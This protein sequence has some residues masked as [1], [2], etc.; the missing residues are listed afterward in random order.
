MPRYPVALWG[1]ARGWTAALL[2]DLDTVSFAPDRRGALEE[3]REH[4]VAAA[5]ERGYVF[6]S[7]LEEV[8]TQTIKVRV[9][10]EYRIKNKVFPVEGTH[11]FL[12]PCVLARV[13]SG[14]LQCSVPSLA[15]QFYYEEG[16]NLKELVNHYVR[17]RLTGSTPY[18]LALHRPPERLELE[19]VTV[20]GPTAR[21]ARRERET[22]ELAAVA[23]PLARPSGRC[24]GREELVGELTGRVQQRASVLLVGPPG[25]GKTSLI[26]EVARKLE[27]T[28]DREKHP[29]PRLWLSSAAR[30]VAGM[31]YLGQWEERLQT[32]IGELASLDGVLVVENLLELVRQGGTEPSGSLAAFLA[33]Y[34]EA[35]E[36]QLVA[37][38][39]P[40]ELIACS[41]ALPQLV[42]MFQVLRVPVL[43]GT[44]AE[45]V[46]ARL[47]E[48]HAQRRRLTV[49]SGAAAELVRLFARFEPYSAF[50]GNVA[51]FL[52][53][54]PPLPELGRRELYAAFSTHTG[55]PE[56][57]LRDEVLLDPEELEWELGE[58]VIGQPAA[59]AAGLRILTTFKAGLQ[60]PERPLGSL[61]LCGPTG[62]GKTELARTLARTMFG[63]EKRL[64]RLDM[65]E[66]SG[67]GAA[68]RLLGSVHDARPSELVRRLRRQPF[69]VVLLDEVEKAHPE[70]FDVLL[71]ALDEGLW[72]D[73]WGRETSFRSAI[74]LLTS[75]L[76]AELIKSVGIRKQEAPSY[77]GAARAFFRPEFL[78]RLDGIISF[79]PLTRGQ[80]GQIAAKEVRA[81]E[82][83]AGLRRRGL[84][85]AP[86]PALVEKLVEEGYDA[87]LGARPLQRALE[88]LVVRGL[89]RYLAAHPSLRDVT[90]A[91]DWKS[92]LVLEA[93]QAQ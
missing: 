7:E 57:F 26:A 72:T 37:E 15:L 70:V 54:L 74:I 69:S 21:A 82:R 59:C 75:N 23:E 83:R 16:R 78:N 60:D 19:L 25:C 88:R 51:R 47:L 63:D 10:A 73:P 20:K 58:Q 42:D 48:L 79:A 40:A 33:P 36:L 61:L 1:D 35:G 55:I 49:Y 44:P 67:V 6:E 77:A 66:F 30:L 8:Q 65:S 89:A 84:R 31:R 64:I 81:L 17:E 38:A 4:L 5:R 9:T 11:E 28:R 3:L 93:G 56:R 90:L 71:R 18:D 27:K 53:G 43:E 68:E 34:L 91:V 80:V 52:R 92:E 14:L 39:T 85:L 41:Q 45:E 29:A 22:P 13:P 50:P 12:F 2:E 46:S 32:V 86:S 24:Y 76:G 87:R 62:V